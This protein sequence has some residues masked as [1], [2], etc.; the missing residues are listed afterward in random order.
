MRIIYMIILL[1]LVLI[2]F[3][4]IEYSKEN[5]IFEGKIKDSNFK[6]PVIN[7]LN[8]LWSRGLE[9]KNFYSMNE[10]REVDKK[11]ISNQMKKELVWIRS[12]SKKKEEYCDLDYFSESLDKLKKDI[13]LITSDGV[14]SIPSDL[15]E[16]TFNKIINHPRIKKWYAQ[17][18]DGSVTHEKIRNYPIGFDFHTTRSIFG[19]PIPF[20][21]SKPASDKINYMLKIRK[22]IKE[23]KNKIFVDVHLHQHKTFNNERKRVKEILYNSKNCNFLNL[24]VDQKSI[25]KKYSDHKFVISAFGKGLDCHR[26]WEC[27]FLGAIVIVKKSSLDPLYKDLPVV[28]LDD[29]D[30]CL[31]SKNLEKWEKEYGHLTDFD[32]L[33]KFFTY[34]YWIK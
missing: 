31:D 22:K 19:L 20:L 7:N 12:T 18:Y 24:G 6:D 13:I 26:T 25:W 8:F 21:P 16:E 10:I 15:K 34:D 29:W 28:I 27:L 3:I 2:I 1:F 9:S 5:N 14:K 17:N 23:K 4:G 30:E 11:L 33:N 32:H